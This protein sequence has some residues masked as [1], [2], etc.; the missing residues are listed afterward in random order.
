MD[1]GR[2]IGVLI[3]FTIA[4]PVYIRLLFRVFTVGLHVFKVKKRTPPAC[5]QD[6]QFGVHKYMKVN[7]IKIHYVE[8][9]EDNKP[10]MVFVH[11]FL[12]M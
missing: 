9:G 6:P 5:L 10:L 1:K 2:V 4:I 3:G 8:A 12:S 11:G 7:G